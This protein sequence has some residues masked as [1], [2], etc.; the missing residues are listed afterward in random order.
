MARSAAL[1][2][3]PAALVDPS[4]LFV[5]PALFLDAALLLDPSAKESAITLYPHFASPFRST[6][7]L[8]TG[9]RYA[10]R[11]EES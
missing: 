11:G 6:A 8:S 5:D 2:V 1:V 10:A 9:L 7:W 4:G 3:S